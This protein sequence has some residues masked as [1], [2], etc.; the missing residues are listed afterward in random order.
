MI[1]FSEEGCD[2]LFR[3]GLRFSFQKWVVIFFSFQKRVVIFFSFQERVGIV[4][5]GKG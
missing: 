5:S 4:F 2:F 1:F 3:R